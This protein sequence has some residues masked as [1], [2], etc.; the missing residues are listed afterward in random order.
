MSVCVCVREI[1]RE[2][3]KGRE[4]EERERKWGV[5]GDI[6]MKFYFLSPESHLDLKNSKNSC[7]SKMLPCTVITSPELGL[8]RH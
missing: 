4:G 2:T 3:E 5:R 1:E 7:S 6:Y 8:E